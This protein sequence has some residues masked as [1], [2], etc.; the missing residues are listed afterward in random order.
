MANLNTH[1]FE[2][3]TGERWV[4]F[5]ELPAL[6]IAVTQAARANATARVVE[7]SSGAVVAEWADGK[8]T[9]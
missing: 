3:W 1:R 5:S 6:N 7:I 8:R 4:K 9:H 2:I